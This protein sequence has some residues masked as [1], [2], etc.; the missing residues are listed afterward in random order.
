MATTRVVQERSAWSKASASG[1]AG[2]R[3]AGRPFTAWGAGAGLEVSHMQVGRAV[4]RFIRDLTAVATCLRGM[5]LDRW[6]KLLSCV[7][8]LSWRLDWTLAWHLQVAHGEGKVATASHCAG[9]QLVC[10][11]GWLLRTG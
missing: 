7:R 11:L 1:L 2:G 5:K 8:G 9:D 4:L 6:M 3:V 10:R